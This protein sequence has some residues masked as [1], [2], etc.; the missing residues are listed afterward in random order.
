MALAVLM[1]LLMNY[2]SMLQPFDV[3]LIPRS[4]IFGTETPTGRCSEDASS[5]CLRECV[6]VADSSP[7]TDRPRDSNETRFHGEG[8]RD[9]SVQYSN[10]RDVYLLTRRR[11]SRRD[12]V[13]LKTKNSKD[14]I[15][16]FSE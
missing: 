6:D 3:F 8:L 14:A 11:T 4:T 2:T 10:R 13:A 7:S 5:C 12:I 1:Y 9:S 15:S 16:R